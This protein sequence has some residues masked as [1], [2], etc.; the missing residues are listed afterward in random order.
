MNEKFY[1]L[2][3]EKQLKIINAGFRVFS[4]NSY[5]KSPVSEI[6]AEAGISKSLLFHYFRNKKELYLFL[7]DR[8][9]EISMERMTEYGCYK[10]ADLFEMM[11]RGLWAKLALMR[12]YPYMTTFTMKAFYEKDPEVS[13]EVQ[14]RYQKYYSLNAA[15]ALKRLSPADF[16]PGL[17]LDMMIK[18]MYWTSEGYLWE[19]LQQGE[20]DIDKMEKD[21]QDLLAF[22]KFIYQNP[23][24]TGRQSEDI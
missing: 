21:F 11:E 7:L 5:K 14:R 15:A 19:R 12:D 1:R 22:W 17:D 8:G 23:A 10:P 2:S 24:K 16:V 18:E 9:A 3:E 4:E 13:A 20:M 6:A